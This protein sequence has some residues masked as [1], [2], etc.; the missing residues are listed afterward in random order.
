MTFDLL[1]YLL[2]YLFLQYS[3]QRK[4]IDAPQSS[5]TYSLIRLEPTFKL[6]FIFYAG[7][8]KCRFGWQISRNSALFMLS[9]TAAQLKLHAMHGLLQTDV[10]L[11][12]ILNL[13]EV[14]KA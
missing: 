2:T 9:H 14:E 6:F 5:V 7:F 8:L 10:G 13:V 11:Y 4:T 1:T 3:K 12:V